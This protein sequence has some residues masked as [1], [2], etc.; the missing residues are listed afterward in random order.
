MVVGGFSARCGYGRQNRLRWSWIIHG[1]TKRHVQTHLM[2]LY[3]FS[4]FQKLLNHLKSHSDIPWAA[5]SLKYD[6][7]CW[8]ISGFV[9]KNG[10]DVLRQGRSGS[11]E[12]VKG[13]NWQRR[14][15]FSALARAH[16][17]I[18]LQPGRKWKAGLRQLSVAEVSEGEWVLR[19]DKFP[20]NGRAAGL[21]EPLLNTQ[22]PPPFLIPLPLGTSFKINI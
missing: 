13:A 18:Q 5:F 21:T 19:R 16:A 4:S 7:Q 3:H 15:G 22:T 9:W 1:A 20:I 8:R 6:K 10:C 12:R 2:T 11:G 14:W 17:P